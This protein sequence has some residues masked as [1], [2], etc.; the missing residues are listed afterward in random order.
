MSMPTQSKIALDRYLGSILIFFLNPVA[1]LLGFL[2]HRDHT[3][4]VRGD[5]LVIKML[6]GG[7]LV[8]A[9]PTLLGIRRA[10]PA[11]KIRILTTESVKAFAETLGLFDEILVVD[12]RSIFGLIATTARHIYRSVGTDTV[13][14]LEIYSYLST[15][16]S[17]LTLA[18][19]RLGFFLKNRAF[20]RSCIRIAF[21]LIRVRPF[22]AITIASRPCSGPT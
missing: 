13:I 10:Y 12:D 18:R 9:F 2:F 4:P 11:V 19:N 5:I 7:S 22:T 20:G 8:M 15:V 16:L 17:I 21:C 6:G 14:D 3:L 1:R